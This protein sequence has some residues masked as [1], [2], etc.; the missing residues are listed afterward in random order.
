VGQV[1]PGPVFTTAT[2]IGYLLGGPAG[3]AVATVGIF[4]RLLF[5]GGERP[6]RPSHPPLAARRRLSRR[7][8]APPWR[9]CS[10]VTYQL[11]RAALVDV[12]STVLAVATSLIVFS[13]CRQ[14]GLLVLGGGLLGLLSPHVPCFER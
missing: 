3:A 12:P 6:A 9:S 10:S 2:F 4:L 1:T 7:V 13:V 11:G 8:N 5:R 14:L